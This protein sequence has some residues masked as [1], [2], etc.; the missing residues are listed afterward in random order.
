MI[1]SKHDTRAS[2]LILFIA[3]F[4]S[5]KK[6]DHVP[7][8]KLATSITV[9]NIL[10][11]QPLV[12]SGTFQGTEEN[13]L[14]LP[15]Q[16]T[17]IHFSAAKGEALAFATMYGWSNDL[18]FAPENPGIQV[19]DSKGMPLEGDVS[20]QIKLW[21]NGTRINQIPGA[22]ITRP[23]TAD[24]QNITE[25]QGVDMQ[26]NIYLDASK[27]V[28]ATLHYDG[29]SFFTLT[30]KNISGGT[31]N[32]TPLS[33]GVWA[34]SYIAGGNLLNGAPLYKSGQPTANG[35]TAL[36]EMGNNGPLSDY[37]KSITGIFTPLSPV[38]VVVY[39]GIDNPIYKTGEK[40]RGQGLKELAQ[41]GNA[42]VL[43]AALMTM[44][45]V[46]YVYVLP[47]PDTKVL[48]PVIGN[49]RGGI[50][51]H[52]IEVEK[53]DRLAIATMYGFSNDWFFATKGNGI[54]PEPGD[55]SPT[56]ELYND[57]TAIDQFPGA[58]ITQFNL[59][60]TPLEESMLIGP[61]PNPNAFTTLPAIT[62][63]IRVTLR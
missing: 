40:D 43:A 36:S 1:I 56:I 8:E 14:I 24:T 12:E 34:V 54:K 13:P 5:C 57:G 30:I 7:P 49:Q 31:M 42:D 46:K 60:G 32:E 17:T 18:F 10:K 63:I 27:L 62:D 4:I 6:D 15:G 26:G 37:I 28:Q 41:K 39:H 21:D 33:P 23:G 2:F 52:D 22:N 19:Y 59:A 53:G 47:A 51:S 50:V 20:A 61:V 3:T 25:V 45:G 9:E 29:N 35:L 11:S 16:S 55:I 44:E 38:L 58:G 48:L